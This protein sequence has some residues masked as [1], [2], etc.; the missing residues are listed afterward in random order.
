MR[1]YEY[2]TQL[3]IASATN[4]QGSSPYD[5]PPGDAIDNDLGFLR[6]AACAPTCCTA[7]ATPC[8][9][10]NNRAPPGDCG[11][12]TSCH[13]SRGSKWLDYN[14]QWMP[15]NSTLLLTLDR[16]AHVRRRHCP[17]PLLLRRRRCRRR[18][19]RP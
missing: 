5:Q 15:R 8:T 13:C 1:L 10:H 9:A 3:A 4:P 17:L 14:M 11:C 19:C 2:G 12:G 16:P 18:R 6:N 7:L